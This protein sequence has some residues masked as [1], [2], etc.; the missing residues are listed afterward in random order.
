MSS[1]FNPP[2]VSDELRLDFPAENVLLLTLNRPQA[3]NAMTPTMEN[4]LSRVLN[5]FEGEP[6]LW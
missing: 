3:R 1:L 5:W 4:D 6:R 2:P